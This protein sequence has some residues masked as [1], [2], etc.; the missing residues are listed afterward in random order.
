MFQDLSQQFLLCGLSKES[1][2]AWFTPVKWTST[3]IQLTYHTEITRDFH[4]LP[5]W[6]ETT[7]YVR[8]IATGYAPTQ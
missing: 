4:L 2:V 8:A 6:D 5:N 1:Q 3:L 7:K